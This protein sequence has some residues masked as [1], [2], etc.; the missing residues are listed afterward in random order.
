MR[1]AIWRGIA[2]AVCVGLSTTDANADGPLP[3]EPVAVQLATFVADITPPL[4]EVLCCGLGNDPLER[5]VRARL[6][7][8]PILAK[9]IVLKDAG[10]TYVLCAFDWGG[11][12][13]DAHDGARQKLAA[14]AG[15]TPARVA[16]QSLHQ[17]T[18]P[19]A[20]TAAQRILDRAP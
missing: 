6:I 14:A 18:S 16:A 2:L 17:H 20:D 12:C 15:T 7:E 8:H 3:P 11:I 4:G 9:G 5:D 19:G 1:R 13:N 10:G